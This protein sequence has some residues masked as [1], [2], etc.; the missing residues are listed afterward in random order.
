MWTQE[1]PHSK[2]IGR[3]VVI[4]KT[5]YTFLPFL[6]LKN[7]WFHPSRG[8]ER[9]LK[10]Q[11]SSQMS[12]TQTFKHHI[13]HSDTLWWQKQQ[14]E[15]HMVRLTDVRNFLIQVWFFWNAWHSFATSKLLKFQIWCTKHFG[16]L[17]HLSQLP[18]GSHI[19]RY[20]ENSSVRKFWRRENTYILQ[21]RWILRE[22]FA[23]SRLVCPS[24]NVVPAQKEMK[25]EYYLVRSKCWIN[26]WIAAKFSFERSK[27]WLFWIFEVAPEVK[28][29]WLDFITCCL[30][31][32][33][34]TSLKPLRTEFSNT[35]QVVQY[36]V[37]Q[38]LYHC[39]A[40]TQEFLTPL[41]S[42][43]SDTLFMWKDRQFQSF[44]SCKIWWIQCPTDG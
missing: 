28:S 2:E 21:W 17:M 22:H 27:G 42:P 30:W 35:Q 29:E 37:L 41:S 23:N 44:E 26:I 39:I 4:W 7:S 38:S 19:S 8:Y 14:T 5:N 3:S 34:C 13:C 43:S 10:I 31:N 20:M 12:P 18:G 32:L 16:L 33:F 9:T 24:P 1:S 25:S 40:Q 36:L 11:K 15:C 6:H